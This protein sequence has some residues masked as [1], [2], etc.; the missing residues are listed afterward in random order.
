[1]Q[2]HGREQSLTCRPEHHE[3]FIAA[4]LDQAATARLNRLAEDRGEFGY[5]PRRCFIAAL[6]GEAGVASN[7]RDEKG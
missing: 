7:I 4:Q 6:L 3:R 2:L 1:L 5:Q